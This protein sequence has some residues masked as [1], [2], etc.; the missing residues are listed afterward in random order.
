MII[1]L[2]VSQTLL[3]NKL[4]RILDRGGVALTQLRLQFQLY[5]ACNRIML[6]LHGSNCQAARSRWPPSIRMQ[7]AQQC[8]SI[9]L[10]PGSTLNRQTPA[11]I[12][13]TLCAAYQ[14]TMLGMPHTE[15]A[16]NG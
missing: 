1:V 15:H 9:N 5:S 6:A 4:A 3:V 14:A 12:A 11:V 8:L 10:Q 13:L 2:I 16:L 7:A